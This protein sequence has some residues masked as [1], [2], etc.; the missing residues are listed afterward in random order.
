MMGAPL[1]WAGG[2]AGA[3]VQPRASSPDFALTGWATA[4]VIHRWTGSWI[5]GVLSGSLM[6]FNALTLTR[7]SH[8]QMLHMEFFPLALLALDRLLIDAARSKHALQLA[9]LVRAAVAD[10][11]VFR[12]CSRAVA[13]VVGGAVRPGD[14]LGKRARAVMPLLALLAAVLAALALLPFMWPYLQARREQEMFGAHAATKSPNTRRTFTNYL[15]TGGT[16]HN[17]TWSGQFFRADGL[18]PGV[19]GLA[20]TLVAMVTGVA[21]KDRRA[22]MALAFGCCRLR[23]VVRAGV[24]AL[25]DSLQDLSADGGGAGRCAVGPDVSCGRRDPRRVRAGRAAARV[26]KRGPCHCR[27]ALVLVANVEAL[28]API[29]VQRR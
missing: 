23:L 9:L 1:A 22:R 25:R 4:V 14:W 2:S 20:L 18:F 27:L 17:R 24:S 5:A 28:R 12:S 21:L 16:I 13:L 19:V 6:A 11:G 8:I 7:L 26:R 15:A 10:V 3:C 29:R